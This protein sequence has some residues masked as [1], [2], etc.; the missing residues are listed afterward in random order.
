MKRGRADLIKLIPGLVRDYRA[1]ASIRAAAAQ[2][3]GLCYTT[4]RNLL[5]GAGVELRSRGTNWA[6]RKQETSPHGQAGWLDR[7]F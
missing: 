3:G 6:R 1:G 4:A 7:I 5:L 2:N